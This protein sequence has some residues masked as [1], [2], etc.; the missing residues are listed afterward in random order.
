MPGST[1]D[2]LVQNTV[3]QTRTLC[4]PLSI[5][6]FVPV[7]ILGKGTWFYGMGGL[8]FSLFN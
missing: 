5:L 7:L 8:C 2:D 6:P 3:E 4:F 1:F